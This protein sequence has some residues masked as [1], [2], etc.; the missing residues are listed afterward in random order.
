[1]SIGARY[2]VEVQKLPEGNF[3]KV[4]LITLDDGRE[5]IAKLPNP[6]AGPAQFTTASEV[7]TMDFVRNVLKV[8]APK[9][10]AWSSSADNAVGAEYILMERSKG[11]ELSKV[12]DEISWEQR[13]EIVRVLVGYEKAFAS[14][15]L[16]SY[17][18]LYYAEDLPSS[19]SCQVV[20]EGAPDGKA[21]AIG[22]TT[23]R[24]FFDDGRDVVEVNRGPWPSIADFILSRAYREL[25]C[26]KKSSAFPGQQGLFNGP[27]QYHPTKAFKA[28][29]LRNYLKV[30]IHILPDDPNLSKP[31]LWHS[32]LHPDNIFVD[33]DQPTKILNIIDW[34]AVNVSPLFL[35]ARHPSL[36]EFEGPIPEGFGPITLPESFDTMSVEEQQQAKNLRAAQ[37]L[38]K[39]YEVLMLRQCPEIGRALMFRD[40]LAGQIT[41]LASSVFSDGEPVLQG[42]LIRLQD[43]WETC[44][45]PSVPCPLSFSAEDRAQQQE[46]EAKWSASVELMHEVLTEIGVYQGWDGLV[47]HDNYGAFKER[48]AQ[49]REKFLDRH[50]GS[51][52][53]RRQRAQAWPFEDKSDPLDDP[54]KF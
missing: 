47:N 7:A 20:L 37:S 29:V 35:Q 24:A 46:H 44:V 16:P 1:Q 33:P 51:D 50:A 52:A 36:V 26:I 31:T 15:R 12:W 32:D 5:V 42:M 39:L 9:V 3:S 25:E 43:E 23:N 11:V 18:S 19:S 8:P 4:F 40:S 48:L 30:A 17:G 45:G 21:F 14:T 41:G 22:P 13:L 38:Y 6:N 54:S 2:C 34:Q 53:E 27:N 10:F 49:C 28:E